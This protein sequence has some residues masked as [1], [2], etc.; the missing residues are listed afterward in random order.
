MLEEKAEACIEYLYQ[1]VFN[2]KCPDGTRE[3]VLG[4]LFDRMKY[5]MVGS[6]TD[7]EAIEKAQRVL[8]VWCDE[9][10]DDG[11][12]MLPDEARRD[13]TLR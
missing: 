11:I 4:V 5:V 12:S 2:G 6:K 3:H 9:C 8:R 7:K 10:T 1:T 13:N